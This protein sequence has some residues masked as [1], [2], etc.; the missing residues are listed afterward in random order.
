MTGNRVTRRSFFRG[1]RW[2]P[3]L[4]LPA[5]LRTLGAVDAGSLLRASI[6]L[7]EL[8]EGRLTPHYPAASPLEDVLRLVAPGSDAYQTEKD[9]TEFAAALSALGGELRRDSKS[10]AALAALTADQILCNSSRADE[11]RLRDSFGIRIRKR[12]FGAETM[13]ARKAFLESWRAWIAPFANVQTAEFEVLSFE[14]S[15][16]SSAG[17]AAEVLFSLVGSTTAGSRE[18]RNGRWRM[19]VKRGGSGAWLVERWRF[20]EE[21]IAETAATL[22]EDVSLNCFGGVASYREQLQRGTDEW[23][24][25]IDGACG[26]DVYGNCGIAAGDFD[27]DGFDDLYICQPA[28][29]PNRL[30]RNRGDGT[31]EDATEK[32]GLG[33]LDA[34]ACAIWADFENRGRQDLLVVCASGPLLYSNQ[35]GGRFE[36]QRDAFAFARAPQG[37]FTHAAVAD[38]DGDGRL[39]VYFCLYSYY[40]GLD[41][42]H[43]P[44]PYYD[45]RNGPPNFL[46]HND[47]GGKFSD[48]TEASGLNAENDRF[49]FAC[50]W[51][52]R[53][54]G[55]G[56][57]L[58]V[59]N[60]F[61]RSNLY[62][63]RGDGTFRPVSEEAGVNV[64]GAGM[65]ACWLDA[66]ND[67][68]QEIYVSNMWSAAGQR[69]AADAKFHASDS[70]EVKESY[71]HHARGNSLYKNLGGGRFANVAEKAGVELGRWAWSSDSWDF[72]HDGFADLYVTNGYI[73]GEEGRP[74]AER[75]DLGSFFWRQVVGNSPAI[76]A[77]SAPYERGW[78]AINEL[79]RSGHTWSGFERNTFYLNN[80]DG[81]FCEVSGV[82]GLD[83]PDDSRAFALADID[84]DGRLE[85]ILKN[86]TAPQLRALRN[87]MG[88]I[89][90]GIAI[91]LRGTRSN[92]DAIG[93]AVTVE[94]GSLR[95]TKLLQAGSGFL[96]QHSKELFFGLGKAS[97]EVRAT[98]HWPSGAQ[99]VFERLPA[100]HRV[101]IEEGS[102]NVASE[103]FRPAGARAQEPLATP[104]RQ[105]G[106]ARE[107]WLIDPLPAPGFT[108]QDPAGRAV[109]LD[110]LRGSPALLVFWTTGVAAA[111]EQL[112]ELQ[113]EVERWGG[114]APRVLLINLDAAEDA[115]KV[116]AAMAKERIS[117]PLAFGTAEV[118]GVYNILFRYLFDR[119]ADLPLPCSFLLDANGN[120]AKVYQGRVP[121]KHFARDAA[122]IPKSDGERVA[123]ALP[124]PGNLVSGSFR[125]ND[126]TY[127]VALFQRGYL[128]QAAASFKQVI[129]ASPDNAEAYYNL[130]TLYLRKQSAEAMEEA[131]GYLEQTVKL[132]PEYPEA[133]NNLGMIAAQQNRPG[134]AQKN[135]QKALELRPSYTVAMINLGNLYRRTGDAAQSEKLL[136]QALMLEPDNPEANYNAAMLAARSGNAAQAETLLEKTVRLREDYPEAWNNWGVLLAQ[137]GRNAD[138]AE[139]FAQCVRVAPNF[140][141]AY[142]N[143]ARVYAL[144]GEKDKA[145]AILQE[146]LRRQPQHRLAQ[147]ALEML[148]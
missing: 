19:D 17:F 67:G 113:Q 86:R 103:A 95:Q 4:L 74:S 51:G 68:L 133:W 55:R 144:L 80:H 46:F 1:F 146:L 75:P 111:L 43:Y 16:E 102:A 39:D 139:K 82:A 91:R 32:S 8:S 93:S 20:T 6:A 136:T 120:I 85:L 31:F 27:G 50:A 33:I 2:A 28:G 64:P 71:R 70:A 99:Q 141:Q 14:R 34:T 49:S 138:A 62:A 73:S 143:L 22:F 37:T 79:I 132:R 117:L 7:P 87:A 148:N 11:T 130:G 109:Q 106:G 125:R 137:Q 90:D 42:Y 61:G 58:Y 119:R 147:Q 72:D 15:G 10:Q 89:G 145:R 83:L 29:L 101:T 142:L 84:H 126:F 59:A 5:P 38:Y 78:N 104:P 127:G 110:S 112:R 35:G 41:Q 76:S 47:G 134:D 53:E 118:A 131:K 57:D 63:N 140:E 97:G 128:D 69:V 129:A 26:I 114:A 21:T 23:R 48:R 123:R 88:E 45:A 108:L 9:A 81:T 36:L 25:L 30:Y 115:G 52:Q 60:D 98:V 56:P 3:A 94:C 12:T 66:D 121:A 105:S 24:G 40:L 96:A 135:F 77:P 107:T 44:S 100:N 18:E 92:R 124:F 13:L 65:S 116:R 54:P 122:N